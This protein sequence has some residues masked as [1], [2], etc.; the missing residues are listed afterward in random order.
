MTLEPGRYFIKCKGTNTHI[1]R[2]QDNPSDPSPIYSDPKGKEPPVF[3]VDK[4]NTL[5]DCFVI[6]DTMGGLLGEK[7]SLLWDF[8]D[9]DEAP[10]TTDWLITHQQNQIQGQDVYTYVSTLLHLH[11]LR[12]INSTT[13]VSRSQTIPRVGSFLIRNHRLRYGG[14]DTFSSS[15]WSLSAIV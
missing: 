13:Q 2:S 5:E 14:A 11:I 10:P 9:Q 6:Q 3:I 4:S 8:Q 1:G 7:D 15:S 12:L